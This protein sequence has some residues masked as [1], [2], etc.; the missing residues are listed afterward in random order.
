MMEKKYELVKEFKFNGKQLFRLR[1]IRS[2]GDVNVGDKGGLV[3]SENIVP[4]YDES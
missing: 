2:F 3:S 1:A 4:H